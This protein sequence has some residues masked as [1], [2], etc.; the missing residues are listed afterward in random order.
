MESLPSFCYICYQ[1]FLKDFNAN[2]IPGEIAYMFGLIKTGTLANWH[3]G[4]MF[5]K[6]HIILACG[7]QSCKSSIAYV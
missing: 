1:E 5:L 2:R 7:I 6:M 3:S 4:K